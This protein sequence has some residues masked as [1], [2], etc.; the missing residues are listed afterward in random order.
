MP[1]SH[2]D[3]DAFVRRHLRHNAMALGADLGLFI[4]G[5]SLAAPSTILPAFAVSLGAPNL[6]IGAIPALMTVG[7]LLPS[8]FAAGYTETLS[9]K[10][11]F[12]L[13]WTIWE[14]VPFLVLAAAAFFLATPAPALALG[15]LLAM[16]LMITGV[17][18]FLMPAWMDVVAGSI[19]TTLRGRFFA[20][21]HGL[22]N[23]GGLAAS[24]ATAWVLATVAAPVSYGVCFLTSTVAMG[25]SFWALALTREPPGV[26]TGAA[27]PLSEYL[28]R[29]PSLLRRNR[30]LAWFL[31]A[32]VCTVMGTMANG[33]FTVY[34]LRAF[35]APAWQ[36]GVFTTVM[37]SGHIAGSLGLGWLA[38]RLGHRIGIMVG[39][40]AMVAANVMALGAPSL[41][42]FNLVFVAVGLH[43]AAV[44]VSNLN[45]LLDFAPAPE[46]RPTYVGLGNTA[47]A[48]VAFL[49][50][51]AAGLLADAVGF[52]AVF[53][54]AAA[55]AATGLGV[56]AT[57]VS[58]PRRAR[59]AAESG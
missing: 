44:N 6:V 47:V 42:A 39:A 43:L 23:L 41:G 33:F 45:I 49:S 19:P 7:W 35:G 53:A 16:L 8:L 13:R 11:P 22:G 14:R 10:L 15:V 52:A 21:A 58:D 26:T 36:A 40:A 55:F 1:A 12:I 54:V 34:A 9:R 56:L 29:M 46:E 24:F 37:L 51:L 30:N 17:G 5:M 3:P 27:S 18:G 31:A 50:P 32:R 59:V 20:V 28:A 38:D 25:L 2:A 57:R 48:P 4:V